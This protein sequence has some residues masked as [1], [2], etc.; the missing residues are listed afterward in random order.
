M[1]LSVLAVGCHPDDIEFSMAGTL[2]L[3]GDAGY[4][5]HYMNVANGCM[6]S[7]ADD[8]DTIVALREAEAKA[9]CSAI[10][11]TWHAPIADDIA[12]VFSSELLARL[13]AVIREVAPSILLTQSPVDYMEDH[14]N[15]A[16]LASTAA[17]CRG[18]R[19]FVTRPARDPMLTDL[20]VYHAQPHGNRDPLRG[21]VRA[22]LYVDIGDVMAR[23]TDML[24]CHK[25]QKEWLD[26]SQG[27]DSYLQTMQQFS[28][29][30][31]RISGAF[32]LAEGWRRRSP[33]GFCQAD[34]D[35]LR[36]ALPRQTVI[37]N[38]YESSL[39]HPR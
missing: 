27:M 29:E 32:A 18:M 34:A 7:V 4:R 13:G 10:G 1:E 8:R 37:D 3:L 35:P 25:S 16:R 19:N 33:I 30:T 20:T 38:E 21:L 17:F 22:G 28:A 2:I 39:N 15:T 14:Q 23:K 12:V 26:A 11:A 31:G 9:A 6:G 5:L 36:D 24:A